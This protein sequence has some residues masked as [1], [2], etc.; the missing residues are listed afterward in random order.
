MGKT[1]AT[2]ILPMLAPAPKKPMAAPLLPGGN[3]SEITL[4]PEAK[5]PALRRPLRKR[6]NTTSTILVTVLDRIMI[7]EEVKR[8][9]VIALLPPNLSAK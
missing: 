8:L 6:H 2:K 4:T 1:E 3:H 5:M 7:M 9:R